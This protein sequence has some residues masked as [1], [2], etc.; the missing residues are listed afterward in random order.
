M[1]VSYSGLYGAHTEV[2][3][4]KSFTCSQSTALTRESYVVEGYLLQSFCSLLHPGMKRLQH[5]QHSR[6]V[7]LPKVQSVETHKDT[8]RQ[9]ELA[10]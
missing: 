1:A 6:N 2:K 7:V 9:L 4:I 5:C 3:H 10:Q 8:Q